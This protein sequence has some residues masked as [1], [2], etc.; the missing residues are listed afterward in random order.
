MTP[1]TKQ[2]GLV[3]LTV[4]LGLLTGLSYDIYGILYRWRRPGRLARWLWD[5]SYWLGVFILVYWFLIKFFLGQFRL[6]H[7]LALGAGQLLYHNMIRRGK[8]ILRRRH[9]LAGLRKKPANR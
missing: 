9:S 5:F 8:K 1:V 3:L 7:L 4:C 2:L 6:W